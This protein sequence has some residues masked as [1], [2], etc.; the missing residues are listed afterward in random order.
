MEEDLLQKSTCQPVAQ[1][2]EFQDRCE[3]PINFTVDGY[4]DAG[5][6]VITSETHLLT[7][8]EIIARVTQTQLHAAEHN[9]ENDEDD[10]N[11]TTKEGSSPSSY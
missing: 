3:T 2:E 5:E 11:V 8:S 1:L 7:D 4:V 9:D 10:G 6:D